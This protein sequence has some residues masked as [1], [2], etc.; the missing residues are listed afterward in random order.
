MG[1][2]MHPGSAR[3]QGPGV[4]VTD[5]ALVKEIS[6]N[7][8]LEESKLRSG[9]VSLFL[10]KGS[11]AALIVFLDGTEV[12]RFE[13]ARGEQL[14]SDFPDLRQQLA[15]NASGSA[16]SAMGGPAESGDG[17][18]GASHS[19]LSTQDKDGLWGRLGH[20]DENITLGYGLNYSYSGVL[21]R[22]QRVTGGFVKKFS[23]LYIGGETEY[24]SFKGE[25]PDSVAYAAKAGT[26]GAGFRIGID[27]I[28]YHI[29]WSP[30]ALPDYFWTES[31]LR[32]KYFARG[33]GT[34]PTK[35]VK[36]FESTAP[37][38]LSHSLEA[39]AGVFRYTLTVAPDAY[40]APIHFLALDDLPGFLGTWGMGVVLTPDGL[41]PGGWFRLA[42]IGISSLRVGDGEMPV[43]IGLGRLAYFG[44]GRSQFRIAW[45]GELTFGLQ[46][47]ERN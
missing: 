28:R 15:A 24:E 44:S 40:R 36:I 29:Q 35:V 20:W 3:A 11:V 26:L 42:P 41:I 47:K 1:W 32:G 9:T 18:E 12:G 22:Q 6:K 38:T 33:A 23:F 45:S 21:V 31:D 37:P 13:K 8:G 10:R 27:Y 19:W 2:L 30:F 17:A 16:G 5:H 39:R 14:L 46:S 4:E 43:K 7:L 25:L 34:E